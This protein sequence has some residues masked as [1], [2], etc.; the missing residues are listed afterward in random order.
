MDKVRIVVATH[1]KYRMPED[2]MYLPLHVGKKGKDSLGYTGDDTGDNISEENSSFC[3]LTGLYWAWKNIDAEYVGLAHYRRHF[4][5]RKK[6]KDPFDNILTSAEFNRLSAKYPVMVPK[7]RKYYI[8]TMYSHYAH[9]HYAQHLDVTRDIIKEKYPR[10]LRSFDKVMKQRSA[11]MFNMMIMRKDL[12][13]DYC[14]WLF[15]IL[16][17]LK[18]RIGEKYSSLSAFQGRF[19]GRVSEILFN[20]WLDRKIKESRISESDIKELPFIYMEKINW[21]NKGT[22]FIKAK[23]LNKKYD[24]S[25]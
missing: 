17:E 9:T 6:S 24:G 21:L 13:D 7:K 18:R 20:V 14:G 3:E 12:F 10:Y 16:F 5:L 4:S 15:T 11:Y 25:F 2:P 22:S 23:F 8:E 19:Y 1:K